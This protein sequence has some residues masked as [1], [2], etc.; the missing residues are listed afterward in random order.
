MDEPIL[1][2]LKKYTYCCNEGHNRKNCP[3]KQ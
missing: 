3:Y 2:R 1:N